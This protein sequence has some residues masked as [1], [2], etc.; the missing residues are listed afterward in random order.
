MNERDLVAALEKGVID[1][2]HKLALKAK[3]GTISA[4]EIAQ[5]RAMFRDAGGTL[6]FGSKATPVG[7]DVL[8]S[9][10]DIDLDML[11]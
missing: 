2:A 7:D 4:A 5:L 10:A 1:A 6:M 9:M 8:A 3:E 11:N